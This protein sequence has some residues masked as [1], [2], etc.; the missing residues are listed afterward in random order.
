MDETTSTST[1][2]FANLSPSRERLQVNHRHKSYTLQAPLM[3][4]TT[5][6]DESLN[7]SSIQ[8]TANNTHILP[9]YSTRT[10]YAS[11]PSDETLEKS[12][13]ISPQSIINPS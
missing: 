3:P 10:R 6:Q 11:L 5:I 9:T 8:V 1:C 12:N 2:T 7:R 13:Q 4:N